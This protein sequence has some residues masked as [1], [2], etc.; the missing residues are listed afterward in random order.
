MDRDQQTGTID[1][2]LHGSWGK[3]LGGNC[4]EMDWTV[5]GKYKH[6]PSAE[7]TQSR[8]RRRP[9]FERKPGKKMDCATLK[10][11]QQSYVVLCSARNKFIC[12]LPIE[13][14]DDI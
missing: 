6:H 9:V 5:E 11:L 14:P 2:R 8:W 13:P 12:T 1:S 4:V 7:G 3:K 10:Q